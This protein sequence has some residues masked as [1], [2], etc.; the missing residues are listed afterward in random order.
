MK[1]ETVL[2]YAGKNYNITLV[3]D[4][5]VLDVVI[6]FKDGKTFSVFGEKSD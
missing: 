2:I 6:I 3:S 1:T 5:S 4:D